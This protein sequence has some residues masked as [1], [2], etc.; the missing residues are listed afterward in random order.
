MNTK[1]LTLSDTMKKLG[2][3]YGQVRRLIKKK[4]LKAEKMG[5]QLFVCPKSIIKYKKA[6][7]VNE[8][9]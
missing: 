8:E 9:S 4:K 5:W 3:N 2:L 7:Q 1:W 6:Q